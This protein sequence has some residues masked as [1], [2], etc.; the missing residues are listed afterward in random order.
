M[1]NGKS[2]T[3]EQC[4]T[5][6][7]KLSKDIKR[8]RRFVRIT[9]RKQ[10][11]K[12]K[13]IQKEIQRGKKTV[14]NLSNIT[15]SSAEFR[16]LGKG[17]KYC[18]KPKRHDQVQL[19]QDAFEFTRRLRLQEYFAAKSS[20][21]D[22]NEDEIC[23]SNFQY[24]K[25]NTDPES[26]FVPPSGRDTSLDFYIDAITNEILQSNKKYKN[27]PNLSPEEL[28]ALKCLKNDVSIVIKKTDKGS[29]VV[30]MNRQDY[31]AEVER[32][33]EDTQFYL[34]CDKNPQKQ[35]QNDIN[36]VLNNIDIHVSESVRERLSPQGSDR[37]PMFYVLP[38]IHKHFDSKLPL[39]YPGRPI[40]S[41]CGSL[42]ENIS[43]YLDSILKPH[44][45]S[46]PSF[47]K[48]S[49]D[50]VIKIHNLKQIPQNAFW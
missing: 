12:Q 16:L 7:G 11:R 14:L 34:K 50:F 20:K 13:K 26:T 37:I 46:L 47:V 19:K 25:R 1:S 31:I 28:E 4:H 32:Q 21:V 9:N 22:E 8:N 40:V 44:M 18:P 48:D 30:I 36:S 24:V 3:T 49:S 33:L 23:D 17:L 45:E 35:F 6:T 43:A 15:L 42:T 2:F 27:A 38:K 29:T 41:G 10:R 39:G 5:T